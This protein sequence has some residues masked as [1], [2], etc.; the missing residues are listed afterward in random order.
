MTGLYYLGADAI[1]EQLAPHDVASVQVEAGRRFVETLV[2]KIEAR[3]SM[4][5]ESTLSGVSLVKRLAAAKAQ[6]FGLEMLFVFVDTAEVSLQRVAQRV[7]K[8][9]HHVPTDDVLRRFSRCLVNFWTRYRE[10]A[11]KW[12]VMY[13]GADGRFDV[14]EG[15]DDQME[16]YDPIRFEQFLKVAEAENGNR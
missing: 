2:A 14:A 10:L 5:V 13:N 7:R 1:A 6:G 4:I 8:G 11:D 16:I 12:S 3:E 15:M 9:G